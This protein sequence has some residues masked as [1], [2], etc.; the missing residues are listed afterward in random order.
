MNFGRLVARS[1]AGILFF[2]SAIATVQAQ[3]T[4]AVHATTLVG[5]NAVTVTVNGPAG[6][7]VFVSMRATIDPDLPT[8]L[9]GRHQLTIGPNGTVVSVFTLAPD[10]WQGSVVTISATSVGG[11]APASTTVRIIAPNPDVPSPIHDH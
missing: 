6:M 1:L 10:Y 11:I 4:L 3:N 9:V 8:V 2:F 5:R 7:P